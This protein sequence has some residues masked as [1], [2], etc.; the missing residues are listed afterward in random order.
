MY[1]R[2]RSVAI[3]PLKICV[4][5]LHGG[6]ARTACAVSEFRSPKWASDLPS[7]CSQMVSKLSLSR[8]LKSPSI[9]SSPRQLRTH[10]SNYK[11]GLTLQKSQKMKML[12]LSAGYA[13]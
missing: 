9:L 1:R 5:H 8:T 4:P 7:R 6:S 13:I 2:C 11:C 3:G 12:S 10:E